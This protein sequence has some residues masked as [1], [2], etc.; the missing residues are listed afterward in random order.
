MIV[1]GI[2]FNPVLPLGA[3]TILWNV[4]DFICAIL[5][6][7]W[8]FLNSEG[9]LGSP[10]QKSVSSLENVVPSE[11]GD[12]KRSK[13]R[14]AGPNSSIITILVFPKWDAI[15][16]SVPQPLEEAA[17][18][19]CDFLWRCM[20]FADMFSVLWF[21]TTSMQGQV[22]NEFLDLGDIKLSMSLPLTDQGSISVYGA[23]DGNEGDRFFRLGFA[24]HKKAGSFLPDFSG[25]IGVLMIDD[26]LNEL[27]RMES[28]AIGGSLERPLQS[29]RIREYDFTSYEADDE[30]LGQVESLKK[31]CTLHYEPEFNP[32]D[33]AGGFWKE[34]P[35]CHV[36]ENDLVT[37]AIKY[38][39]RAG[40]FT[41]ISKYDDLYGSERDE[42]EVAYR[43]LA[44]ELAN[45]MSGINESLMDLWISESP[46]IIRYSF[47]ELDE[48]KI[49]KERKEF[50]DKRSSIHD[51]VKSLAR[52][53]AG[54]SIGRTHEWVARLETAWY[55]GEAYD[56]LSKFEHP[57]KIGNWY[58]EK[59]EIKRAD[60]SKESGVSLRHPNGNIVIKEARVTKDKDDQ[61]PMGRPVRKLVLGVDG[62][63]VLEALYREDIYGLSYKKKAKI[64][65]CSEERWLGEFLSPMLE[66]KTSEE[67]FEARVK[68]FREQK[69]DWEKK[70]GKQRKD[71]E[72][73]GKTE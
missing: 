37:I 40:A 61:S 23:I 35:G 11:T 22:L 10:M 67:Y 60:G 17:D 66:L 52:H 58:I 15:I 28:V 13:R 47:L 70:F 18:K 69:N 31:K 39:G 16:K 14:L 44:P 56:E 45:Q 33:D 42:F 7:P 57:G 50:L 32:V 3:R 53:L 34:L 12:T 51:R 25:M 41:R 62:R 36:F 46:R 27:H 59:L 8:S 29:E 73:L 55:L 72:V 5:F 54:I 43:E 48:T 24:Y 49:E 21:A 20:I 26:V 63:E 30:N 64:L 6:M 19:P 4:L 9:K 2:L 38:Q 68:I 1:V 65:R 71:Q